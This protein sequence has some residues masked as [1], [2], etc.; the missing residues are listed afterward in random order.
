[1]TLAFASTL[2]VRRRRDGHTRQRFRHV[3]RRTSRILAAHTKT[4]ATRNLKWQLRVNPRRESTPR[5]TCTSHR[6]SG[7][8]H[9]KSPVRAMTCQGTCMER[10]AM[11]RRT[12]ATLIP[13]E[14]TRLGDLERELVLAFKAKATCTLA[15]LL[16]TRVPRPFQIGQSETTGPACK[17]AASITIDVSGSNDACARLN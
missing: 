10:G 5:E 2:H 9:T 12:T 3:N 14:A 13:P 7:V 1:M 17:W 15:S 8:S 16:A 6:V 11:P 4:S